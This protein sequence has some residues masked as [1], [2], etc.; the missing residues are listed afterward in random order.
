MLGQKSVF[1][2]VPIREPDFVTIQDFL[3]TVW[4]RNQLVS[5][6]FAAF[7]TLVEQEWAEQFKRDWAYGSSFEMGCDCGSS[8]CDECNPG[9]D[10]VDEEEIEEPDYDV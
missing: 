3:N 10:I 1:S 2:D 6:S 8:T 5:K 4:V 9:W 7:W